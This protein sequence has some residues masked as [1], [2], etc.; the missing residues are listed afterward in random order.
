MNNILLHTF[1]IGIHLQKIPTKN[2]VDY[3]FK[4]I[5]QKL[6]KLIHILFLLNK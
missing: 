2:I 4:Y 5:F 3:N 1:I 6:I